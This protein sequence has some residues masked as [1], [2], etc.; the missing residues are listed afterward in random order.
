MIEDVLEFWFGA[1]ATTTDEFKRKMRRWFMGGPAVDAQIRERFGVQVERALAGELDD[2]ARTTRGRLALILLLDQF[3][4]SIYRDSPR[5]YAGDAKA[6][7]LAVEALDNGSDREMSVEERSFLSMPLAHSENLALQ[8]RNV[9]VV[10]ALVADAAE[11]QR[12]VLAMATE[13]SRKYRDLIARFGRF[14]HRNAILGRTSTPE[15]EAFLVDWSAKMP[16]SGAKD[17]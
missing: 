12:P 11:F 7:A 8:E 2:W 10:N 9:A 13:Q 15:E 17:L 1:P 16:P 6:Q 14:P 5:A 4:R 3:T